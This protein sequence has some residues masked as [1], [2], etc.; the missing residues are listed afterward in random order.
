MKKSKSVRF[1]NLPGEDDQET[2]TVDVDDSTII[3]EM[4]NTSKKIINDGSDA[5]QSADDTRSPLHVEGD[6]EKSS[7]DNL[8]RT[9]INQKDSYD[10]RY[11]KISSDGVDNQQP[12][13][14][15]TNVPYLFRPL[16]RWLNPLIAIA[17]T[18]KISESD[19]WEVPPIASVEVLRLFKKHFIEYIR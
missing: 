16:L 7:K 14:P 18:G 13:H 10:T 6:F 3:F 17:K 11:S 9:V 2:G 15:E 8:S 5:S 12:L 4:C 19:I 1:K